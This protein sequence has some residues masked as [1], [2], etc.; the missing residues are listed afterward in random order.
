[1]K[2]RFLALLIVTLM[3]SQISLAQSVLKG[4]VVDE[5]DGSPL[6][7]A[8][9]V[10]KGTSSGTATNLDGSFSLKAPTGD[11]AIKVSYVGYIAKT[12]DYNLS[13]GE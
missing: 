1:M 4:K 9:V 3:F 11:V 5:N 10:V 12:F 6:I 8:T 7:G 2:H 13:E